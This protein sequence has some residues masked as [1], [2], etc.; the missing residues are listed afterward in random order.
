MLDLCDITPGT[1]VFCDLL[2]VFVIKRLS[3]VF[4]AL[5]DSNL[6]NPRKLSLHLAQPIDTGAGF[7]PLVDTNPNLKSTYINEDA[8]F[9][10]KLEKDLV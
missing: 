8:G 6:L 10:D 9:N 1:S 3:S 2:I 4:D 7:K 5:R